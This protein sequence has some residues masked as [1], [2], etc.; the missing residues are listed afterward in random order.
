MPSHHDY[1]LRPGSG[2][3]AK[4]T[5]HMSAQLRAMATRDPEGLREQLSLPEV[6]RLFLNGMRNML[7]KGDSRALKLYAEL[8]GMLDRTNVS[9]VAELGGAD[10]RAV[11]SVTA[12]A[13]GMGDEER[14]EGCVA[15]VER[16]LM[17][18]PERRL[19]VLERLAGRLLDVRANGEVVR[20]GVVNGGA[21]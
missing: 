10:A 6:E 17:E 11:M 3:D 7:A 2:S 16:V 1:T 12:D 15:Y 9:L 8:R 19:G 13:M 14:F 18:E 21:G 5:A 4:F 20:T